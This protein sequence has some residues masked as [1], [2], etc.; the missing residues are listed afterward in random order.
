MKKLC[1]FLCP[2]MICGAFFMQ[3]ATAYAEESEA[4]IESSVILESV[5]IPVIPNTVP[6]VPDTEDANSVSIPAESVPVPQETDS[7]PKGNGSLI[8]DVSNEEV[9]HQFI[10]VKSKGGH[11]FYIIIDKD[12]KTE[13]VY[14]LNAVDEYD[15]MAFAED[16]PEEVLEELEIEDG[17]TENPDKSVSKDDKSN[18]KKFDNS[19]AE[20]V[21]DTPDGGNNSTVIIILIAAAG[22]GGLVYFKVIKP[23]KGGKPNKT[24]VYDD[25]DEEYEEE[26]VNEDDTDDEQE[27]E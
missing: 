11:V 16:F 1:K 5:E 19:G 15:L 14:F 9:N 20:T 6:P 12:S 10:T 2:V 25:E 4:T 23:K 22:I 3:S 27:D 21:N 18:Q 8:E 24:A 13:N 26:T 17:N 7:I